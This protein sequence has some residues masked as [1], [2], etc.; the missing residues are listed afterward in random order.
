MCGLTGFFDPVA[1]DSERALATVERMA[2]ALDH[3][4]PDDQS[5]WA[6]IVCFL[7]WVT[8]CPP[9]VILQNGELGCLFYIWCNPERV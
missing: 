5:L 7:S 2:G 1:T 4:G 6:V 3:R 8:I 9:P